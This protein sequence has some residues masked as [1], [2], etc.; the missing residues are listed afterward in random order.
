[1]KRIIALAGIL[2][3]SAAIAPAIARDYPTLAERTRYVFDMVDTNHDGK[4]SPT[5]NQAFAER[6]FRDAD[7]NGDGLVSYDEALAQQERQYDLIP[8][9]HVV[10]HLPNRTNANPSDHSITKAD[11]DDENSRYLSR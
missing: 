8:A 7:T 6:M 11:P 5:E 10:E 4:I 9:K 1:M 3:F 2:T